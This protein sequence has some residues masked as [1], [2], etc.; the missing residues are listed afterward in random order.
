MSYSIDFT[1]DDCYE[2]T[3]VLINKL[4][5]RDENELLSIEGTLTGGIAASMIFAPLK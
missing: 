5:I 3:S 1:T 2:G 4:N